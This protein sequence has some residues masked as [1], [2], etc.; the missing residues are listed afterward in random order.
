MHRRGLVLFLTFLVSFVYAAPEQELE[1]VEIDCESYE[2]PHDSFTQTDP[3]KV[4]L[5]VDSVRAGPLKEVGLTKYTTAFG[6]RVIG[7]KAVPD[8]RII[9]TAMLVAQMMDRD[10]DG[11]VDNPQLQE[12]LIGR[13]ASLI[14]V[15]DET[16]T[17][18]LLSPTEGEGLP[19]ELKFCPFSID[20]EEMARIQPGEAPEAACPEDLFEKDRTL[21]FVTDHVVG[22][23]W[24]LQFQDVEEEPGTSA[25]AK[26]LKAFFD[27]A[28]ADGNFD[29]K[30]TGCPEADAENCNQVMFVS[31]LTSTSLGVDRC[32]C[33]QIDAWKLC[34]RTEVDEKYPELL[35]F[36]DDKV[37]GTT[38]SGMYQPAKEDVLVV[39]NIDEEN[40]I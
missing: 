22:R 34:D 12:Q 16:F 2:F 28:V 32:Y 30:Q 5:A 40:R 33:Q 6:V 21:A 31:W 13:F 26:K 4:Y 14:I 23:G 39:E 20:F 19:L 29:P 24:P 8:D 15:S 17:N 18:F 3:S 7:H 10:E 35:A 25:D 37:A 38:P 1:Q 36:I 9:H 27:K 11:V